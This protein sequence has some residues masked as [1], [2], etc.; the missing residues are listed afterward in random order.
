[1][2][3]V[4]TI[5]KVGPY[6]YWKH[7]N[8]PSGMF[9]TGLVNTHT[10][11]L[12]MRV[13]W[14][15]LA[16]MLC[17]NEYSSLSVF[18]RLVSE[19]Y[20]GDDNIL[21]V[22]QTVKSWFNALTVGTC[23][24][25]YGITY[26]P[27]EKGDILSS[28]LVP[29]CDL[30]FLKMTTICPSLPPIPSVQFYGVT[31]HKNVLKSLK[32]VS[33]ELDV[34]EATEVNCNDALRRTFTKG[35]KPFNEFRRQISD[36]LKAV[37]STFPLISYAG[38][39]TLWIEGNLDIFAE[40]PSA[41]HSIF[42]RFNYIA[43]RTVHSNQLKGNWGVTNKILFRDS[44]VKI[45]SQMMS[46]SDSIV[47]DV[48]PVTIQDSVA[49]VTIAPAE[50]K[51]DM[52]NRPDLYKSAR[53]CIKRYAP[54]RKP[55][56]ITYFSRP[57]A[58]DY[59]IHTVP[60][61]LALQSAPLVWWSAPFR[62]YKGSTRFQV[63]ANTDV[64]CTYSND[65]FN[66]ALLVQRMYDGTECLTGMGP[67]AVGRR[68]IGLLGIQVPY[69]SPFHLLKLPK[70]PAD[71]DQKQVQ[72][73]SSGS[74]SFFNSGA[75]D[76]F[77][78]TWT[79]AG[80][81][82]RFSYLYQVPAI[83]VSAFP[84]TPH[85][86]GE[87]F[88]VPET[89]ILSNVMATEKFPFDQQF[90]VSHTL[91][92]DPLV[93]NTIPSSITLISS[94]MTN[95]ELRLIGIPIGRTQLRETQLGSS[96][97]IDIDL[98]NCVTTFSSAMMDVYRE[99]KVVP[100]IGFIHAIAQGNETRV[101]D[102]KGKVYRVADS[103]LFP[104]E[105]LLS[106]N[107]RAA[108]ALPEGKLAVPAIQTTTQFVLE[109]GPPKEIRGVNFV[110]MD[111]D[112]QVCSYY[113]PSV[114]TIIPQM[115]RS[116]L[117]S[118]VGVS[119]ADTTAAP[120]SVGGRGSSIIIDHKSDD[121]N[122][123]P[124]NF[125]SIVD[126]YQWVKTITW[127][128]TQQTNSIL[129]S[130]RIP[131]GLLSSATNQSSFKSFV[132]WKGKVRVKIQLQSN[133][134]QQGAIIAYF[135]PLTDQD[136]INRHIVSDRTSQSVCPHVFLT[137]GS[138]RN[139][140][141]DIPFVHFLKRLDL[142]QEE[143]PNFD[144]GTLVISVFNPL[145]TGEAAEGHA[146]NC[147]IGVFGSFPESNFQVL[148]PTGG[149]S[150]VPQGAFSSKVTHVSNNISNV[151][152]S[153]VDFKNRQ[154]DNMEGG[155]KNSTA[156]SGMDKPNVGVNTLQVVRKKYPDFANASNI[157]QNQVLALYP[158]RSQLMTPD[159]VGSTEDEM[160]FEY[161]RVRTKSF[162]TTL[163]W[164]SSDDTGT[165]LFFGEL[166]P[167]PGVITSGAGSVY[168]PTLLEYSTLP[169]SLWRGGLRLTVQIVGS[170]VHSGRIVVCTH[171]GRTSA[172]IPFE[173][174]MS[175]YAH[176]FDFSAEKN[177]FEVDFPWR[178]SRQMLRVPC[179]TFDDLSDFSMGE[180][181]IRVINPLQVMDSVASFVQINLYWSACEDF[182]ADFL[183]ANTIDLAP[184]VYRDF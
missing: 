150:I 18:R 179:G 184:V 19:K 180:F 149:V 76:A 137:A 83:R 33:R 99:G 21:A 5:V 6:L 97:A 135:V 85:G 56:A 136:E 123:V 144:L 73:Y 49:Q 122:E 120:D 155:A 162:L 32:Y 98:S 177:T 104:K 71:L 80:D 25:E 22:H 147:K 14:L 115:L 81:D 31:E 16:D 172:S 140:T 30:S 94:E 125:A 178:S 124:I 95:D 159:E 38:C 66:T 96:Y 110:E 156:V 113:P 4:H 154:T 114:V 171:Y 2:T 60:E 9:L 35:E 64:A 54:T 20:Y 70:G 182:T 74:V 13:V 165:T 132:Y 139:A 43:P 143:T 68:D 72:Y 121:M 160:C 61:D 118:K 105:N 128:T 116:N 57:V 51:Q 158:G 129:G 181:S 53:D 169:F 10:N 1:M 111:S 168:Q 15:L 23:L 12:F 130:F 151:A 41:T 89:I 78:R 63:A 106:K 131:W 67:M 84:I 65:P 142:G 148:D 127:T 153:T 103:W 100:K 117:D 44:K 102:S 175:Q 183:G 42:D 26:T 77:G 112:S 24:G 39:M 167:C 82:M 170:K 40:G 173:Q 34:F 29:I 7:H 17:L 108:L 48:T 27:A 145:H 133:M 107:F 141:L 176:V 28:K 91:Q 62:V 46:S 138:S 109:S 36:A 119:F 152:D 47:S 92:A 55:S 93:G 86:T 134:F 37:G 161:L 45:V 126:R 90:L 52:P 166:T 174:A 58:A 79:A 87:V 11:A 163:E 75:V 164:K 50:V 3:T 8:N 157:E 88:E 59:A 69:I 101:S 146:L